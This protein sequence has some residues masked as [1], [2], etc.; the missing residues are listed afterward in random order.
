MESSDAISR[1]RQ[2]AQDI[3]L[4]CQNIDEKSDAHNERTRQREMTT[5]V[6]KIL[7]EP[8]VLL[9]E[10]KYVNEESVLNKVKEALETYSNKK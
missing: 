1:I 10:G 8:T 2:N 6:N 9:R 3:V 4:R 7:H 5:K